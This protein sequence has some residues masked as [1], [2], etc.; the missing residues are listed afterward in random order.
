MFSITAKVYPYASE[1]NSIRVILVKYYEIGG[2]D[3]MED[4]NSLAASKMSKSRMS[5]SRTN[6]SRSKSRVGLSQKGKEV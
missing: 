1:I 6:K 2:G 3:T 4:G 5:R